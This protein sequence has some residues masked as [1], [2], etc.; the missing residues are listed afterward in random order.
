[1]FSGNRHT[2]S[3][4]DHMT[5]V[6]SVYADARTML[7][8]A[9]AAAVGAVLTGIHANSVVLITFGIAF[10][11]V[12]LGRYVDMCV[13]QRKDLAFD[14]PARARNWEIH[15]T[16]GGVLIAILHGLWCLYSFVGVSDGFAQLTSTTISVGTLV[17]VA[18]RNFA[19]MRLVTLQSLLISIPL[20]LGLALT[21]DVF[22]VALALILVPFFASIYRIAKNV[23]SLLLSAM[24][25]RQEA[26]QLAEELDLALRT[27]PHGLCMID[28]NGRVLIIND[29]VRK[30][31]EIDDD[32]DVVGHPAADVIL[33]AMS[34]R[35]ISKATAQLLIA[36]FSASENNKLVFDLA[37]NRHCEV[38]SSRQKGHTVMMFE[39]ISDR[40]TT[41]ARISTMARYDSLTQLPNRTFFSEQVKARLS[42]FAAWDKPAPVMAAIIDIDDFKHVNDTLGHP[43]GDKLI[44]KVA[45]RMVELFGDSALVSRF[46]GDEFIIFRTGEVSRTLAEEDAAAISAALRVP[47]NLGTDEWLVTASIGIVLVD[48]ARTDLEEVL[49]RVDLALHDAKARGKACWSVF[50]REMD[51]EYRQRQKLKTQLQNAIDKGQLFVVYQ[52]IVDIRSRALVGCEALVRWNHPDLGIVPPAMFIPL[53][54]ETG[55]ITA[56]SRF[57]LATAC[58]QCLNWPTHMSVSVNLS[59][60]DFRVTSVEQMVAEA[61]ETAGLSTKR[62]IVEVTE[63]AMIEEP[64][65]VSRALADLRGMGVGVALDDFGTGYSSLGYL[66][67]MSFSKLKIDRSFIR[68]IVSNKRALKLLISVAR[69]SHDLDMT[70]TVEGVETEEQLQAI[71]ENTEIK[72]AQGFL[73]GAPLSAKDIG[74]LIARMT[75]NASASRTDP[76]KNKRKMR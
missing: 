44:K 65:K 66:T 21:G 36:E 43:V 20:A 51:V 42:E 30:M 13:F 57:V 56:L 22:N 49:T 33:Y 17:G 12:G 52:P 50:Q 41:E 68:D 11:V 71:I 38:T 53:A 47:F 48:G 58:R 9:M 26:T 74:E 45:E 23:R 4:T 64:E 72:H 54:E 59:A 14:D 34:R 27:M 8:G 2:L 6:R 39:D 31:F 73:F 55:T 32:L 1:M 24:R 10:V 75:P 67:K 40:V 29:Q 63:S 3:A 19:I 61:I 16:I 37:G 7:Y 15:A 28:G 46:G 35:I 25:G 70:V 76:A 60:N 69:L 62:L 18:A 5:F